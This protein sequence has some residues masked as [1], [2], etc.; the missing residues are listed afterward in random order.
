MNPTEQGARPDRVAIAL[1]V[2]VYVFLAVAGNVI[3][4]TVLYFIAPVP[5]VVATLST[6]AAA[7]VANAMTLRIW[8]HGQLADIGMQWTP[9]SRWNLLIG[10]VGGVAA[11][12][13]ATLAP[14]V[15]RFSIL[16]RA[17]GTQVQWGSLVF[18]SV[19]LLF[20]AV[21]EE[22]LFRG[23]AF[24]FLIGKMGAYATILPVGVLFGLMH[25]NN[26]NQTW[27]GLAN[28]ILFGILFGYA[29]LRS[30]DL[31]LLIGLHFGW[32]WILPLFG[33]N[34]SGFTM[35]VTGLATRPNA[36]WWWTGGNYGPEGSVFTTVVIV[37]LVFYLRAVPVTR[38]PSVLAGLSE[39]QES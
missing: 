13:I 21:G 11:A 39:D 34:L 14:V 30:G 2:F 7:A 27:L 28:T 15:L 19:L 38:Q 22:M 23:Y 8:V 31:W 12:L 16:E 3:F 37:A 24:Q 33:A 9:A 35:G 36:P 6:F 17:P 29:F 4:P 25:A 20:G 18:V 10:F 26:P 32:N 5:F 1:R